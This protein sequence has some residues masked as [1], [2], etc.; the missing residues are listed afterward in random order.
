MPGTIQCRGKNTFKLTVSLGSNISGKPIRKSKTFKGSEAA[1]KKELA[2]F[3]TECVNGSMQSNTNLS[4]SDFFNIWIVDYASIKLKSS[5]VYGYKKTFKNNIAD[6]L[7]EAKMSKIKP[8]DIQQWINKI[9]LLKS[10]KTVKNA[11]SLLSVIFTTAV[12]WDIIPL[13]PCRNIDLP[14]S[15]RK[16]AA[17]YNREELEILF[18]RLSSIETNNQEFKYRV[19][20]T[21]TAFT[22]LRLAE[23]MGLTWNDVDLKN[24]II[25][26]NK[27]RMNEPGKGDYIDTPKTKKSVRTISIPQEVVLL[28]TQLKQTQLQERLLLGNKWIGS[29]FILLSNFG[30]PMFYQT[31]SDWFKKFL[32]RENLKHITFHQLRHTHATLLYYLDIDMMSIS[33]RLGHS[34][35]STTQNIYTHL[36]NDID[37]EISDKMSSFINKKA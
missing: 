8:L 27:V 25:D 17:F 9:S 12:K 5:T 21:L 2:K 7:G 33:R 6:Y 19:A 10:P 28:L 4:L 24:G 31:P 13:S 23:L 1:A 36:F 37:K 11:S 3:Y 15:E 22:G 16:E 32:K 14:P 34:Q 30:T 20:I 26:V 18:K 29:D 35:L